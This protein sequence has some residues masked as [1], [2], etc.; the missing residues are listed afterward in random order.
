MSG[1]VLDTHAWMWLAIDD[2]QVD[3]AARDVLLEAARRNEMLLSAISVWEVAML[4]AK[5]RIVLGQSVSGWIDG[6]LAIRGLHLV[7]LTPE[8]AVASVHLPGE[9][10]SDP[11]DRIIVATA[12][13]LGVAVATRGGRI[14][15]YGGLG[16]VRTLRI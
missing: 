8:I 12:R 5:G 7:P 6:A 15:D 2:P 13:T 4:E 14:L 11:A 9:H 3:A 10:P 16:H 1:Y